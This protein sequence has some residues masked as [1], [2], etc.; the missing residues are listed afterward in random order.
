[1]MTTADSVLQKL[2]ER[3]AEGLTREEIQTIVKDALK[4]VSGDLTPADMKLY[5]ELESLAQYIEGAKRELASIQAT[6]ISS[7]HIP[8]ATDELDAVVGATEDATNKIMNA[9]D[10]IM[11]IAGT[12]PDEPNQ[13]LMNVV[14]GIYEACNF[15]DITGQRITKV[16]RT[17]KHIEEQVMRLVAAFGGTQSGG[18][19]EKMVDAND[20]TTLLNGPQLPNNAINQDDI[21][22]LMAS[23]D[24]PQTNN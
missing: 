6:D 2:K 9:C 8:I 4:G 12:L 11:E 1:M 22:A 7:E 18:R 17:L 15:Q 20:E 16:V 5:Q 13:K 3:S 10:Q 14:T 24:A 23:F 19:K 21:D